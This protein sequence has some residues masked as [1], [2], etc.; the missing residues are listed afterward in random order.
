MSKRQRMFGGNVWN[1]D[2]EG[3]AWIAA[4]DDDYTQ[5]KALKD[6]EN[7]LDEPWNS[8][9]ERS[10]WELKA[11]SGWCA[12]Q[13]RCDW[14]DCEGERKGSYVVY[15]MEAKPK[16]GRGWFLVWIVRWVYKATESLE[17]YDKWNK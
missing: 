16:H 1:F 6:A 4:K 2:G 11:S 13:C 14:M 12:Y 15:E 7:E 17:E 3:D 10:N 5:K 8:D 9:N